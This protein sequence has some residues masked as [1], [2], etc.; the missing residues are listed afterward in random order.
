MKPIEIKYR[1][2]GKEKAHGLA[3][4]EDGLIEIDSRLRGQEKLEIIIHE[5]LHVLQPKWAEDRVAGNA[6]E[7]SRILYENNLRFIEDGQ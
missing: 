5:V 4:C 7:I 3:W 1:K 6:R 2:L